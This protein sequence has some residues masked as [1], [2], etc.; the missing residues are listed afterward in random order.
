MYI[1]GRF[2]LTS[3]APALELFLFFYIVPTVGRCIVMVHFSHVYA[4]TY[5]PMSV[6][7]Y[8]AKIRREQTAEPRSTILVRLIDVDK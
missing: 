5:I 2:A 6:R 1:P 3:T 4:R 7:S 8:V